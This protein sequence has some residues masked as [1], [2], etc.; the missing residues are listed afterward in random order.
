MNNSVNGAGTH[1]L[2]PCSSTWKSWICF[3]LFKTT[4][5]YCDRIQPVIVQT[6]ASQHGLGAA[7]IQNGCTITFASKTLIDV[8][9]F[10][11]YIECEC[12][13]VCFGLK[14]FHTH[15]YGRHITVQNNHKPM[16]IIQHKAINTASPNSTVH[17]PPTT[18][19]WHHHPL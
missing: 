5:T 9:T 7:L 6:A 4:L 15:I 8:K 10:Y 1:P 18:E 2:M 14:K 11:A 17:I 3:T 12:L 16:E 19:I 13:S